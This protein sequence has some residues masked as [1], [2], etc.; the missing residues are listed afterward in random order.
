M[1][2]YKIIQRSLRFYWKTNLALSLGIALGIAIITGSILVGNSVRKSL[3]VFS[4]QR[5]G[6][7]EYAL[8]TKNLFSHSLAHKLQ[9]KLEPSSSSSQAFVTSVLRRDSVV[10]NPQLEVVVPSVNLIAVEENFWAFFPDISAPGLQ[11]RSVLINQALAQD[12]QAKKGDYLLLRAQ[13]N[14]SFPLDSIFSSHNLSNTTTSLRVKVEGILPNNGG[15]SFS[16]SN[17]SGIPRNIFVS[18]SWYGQVSSEKDLANILLIKNPLQKAPDWEKEIRAQ[19]SIND[20][21]LEWKEDSGSLYWQSRDFFLSPYYIKTIREIATKKQAF[22]QASSMYLAKTI[23]S[24]GSQRS[25]FYSV[26]AGLEEKNISEE[27]ITINQWLAD[28]LKADLGDKL[29]LEYWITRPNGELQTKNT[30]ATIGQIIPMDSPT[31]SSKLVPSLN[32]MTDAEEIDEWDVPFPLDWDKI[33]DRDEEYWKQYKSTPKAFVSLN[34]ARSWWQKKPGSGNYITTLRVRPLEDNNDNSKEDTL[35]FIE[36]FVSQVKAKADLAES[37][38]ILRSIKEELIQ[39]SQGSTDFGGLFFAMSFFLLFSASILVTALVRLSIKNRCQQWGILFSQ[40]FSSQEVRKL[41]WGENLGIILV[42]AS[43]GVCLGIFYARL[44]IFWLSTW[45]KGAIGETQLALY[46]SSS[47]LILGTFI[48]VLAAIFSLHWGMKPLWKYNALELLGG[49]RSLQVK[50]EEKKFSCIFWL[51]GGLFSLASLLMI[52]SLMEKIPAIL[53]FFLSGSLLLAAFLGVSYLCLLR[54]LKKNVPSFKLSR[55]ALRNAV[56]Y[57]TNSM[58]IIGLFACACFTLV[59]VASNKRN[60]TQVGAEQLPG[61]GGFSIRTTA[62][63]PL[64]QD[65]ANE[66]GQKAFNFSPSEKELLK[67][68][69]I[70]SCSLEVGEDV[71]CRNLAKIK[72][73][74]ILGI[75]LEMLEQGNF[76]LQTKRETKNWAQLLQNKL[77]DGSIPALGDANSVQ[78]ILHSG[79]EKK[80]TLEIA[81]EK[82]VTLTFVGLVPNSIFASEVLISQKH[83]KEFFPENSF[84]RYHLIKTKKVEK[85]TQVLRKRLGELGVKVET[86][87]EILNSFIQVQNTYLSTFLTLGGLGVGLGAIGLIIVILYN[88][89]ER[90]KE[91]ALMLALGYSPRHF[92]FLTVGEVFTLLLVGLSTGVLSALVAIIPLFSQKEIQINFSFLGGTLFIVILIT[93]I[94]SSFFAY[95]ALR[96]NSIKAL[97]SE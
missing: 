13:K 40:G 4:L 83:F 45:W 51:T 57:R 47:S 91:F 20:Y 68:S 43:T 58:L 34:M 29:Q 76:P 78:W 74:N 84:A 89:L 71:S 39:S 53:G 25:I 41:L 36:D 64:L 46:T 69:Q 87:P 19:L 18:S 8:E 28:D 86:T 16:L 1:H 42:G 79:L 93:L 49:Y 7:V 54:I 2:F 55:L 62:T 37:G 94:L 22:C 90:K 21:G 24:P 26:I 82:E 96:I 10:K 50:W 80:I 77:Q 66:K 5:V 61:T 72:T 52:L 75:N 59:A 12:L 23:S 3:E 97:R 92:L 33:K 32:G 9:K 27:G 56:L 11:G 44:L 65:W 6:L 38:F 48:G 70:F 67:E 31:L 95:F 15:G 88:I 81:H 17:Q 30:T 73:P 35:P 14:S 85:L 63:V 60:F